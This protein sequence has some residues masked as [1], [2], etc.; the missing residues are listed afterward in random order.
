MENADTFDLTA[1][2]IGTNYD[3][4]AAR[5]NGQKVETEDSSNLNQ[6]MDLA[7]AYCDSLGIPR[8]SIRHLYAKDVFLSPNPNTDKYFKLTAKGGSA[9][10]E[11]GSLVV[12]GTPYG[13]LSDGN[14]AGH[15]AISNGVISEQ[16]SGKFVSQAL[17]QNDPPGSSVALLGYKSDYL[18]GWLTPQR[19]LKNPMA[20]TRNTSPQRTEN[21]TSRPEMLDLGQ[22]W[23]APLWTISYPTGWQHSI[24][25]DGD[26]FSN[27]TKNPFY[28]GVR[29]LVADVKGYQASEIAQAYAQSMSMIYKNIKVSPGSVQI[30]NHS[31]FLFYGEL[32]IPAA[33]INLIEEDLI[34]VEN[35]K[36]FAIGYK[37]PTQLVGEL[38]DTWEKMVSTLQLK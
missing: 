17:A 4:F 12:F 38:R 21:P 18:L 33:N 25:V 16:G 32:S 35:G 2:S 9:R 19:S 28:D 34:G 6:C 13:K 27:D 37:F 8:D 24:Q 3:S 7:F 5:Y 20:G 29:V 30:G 36:A 14:F 23:N 26:Y 1:A 31:G 15:I 11:K 10:P 22:T